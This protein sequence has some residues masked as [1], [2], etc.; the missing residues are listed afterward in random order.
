MEYKMQILADGAIV[1]V[2]VHD[3]GHKVPPF[4][5]DGIIGLFCPFLFVVNPDAAEEG[6]GFR[7]QVDGII[8][9]A[10]GVDALLHLRPEQIMTP[11]IL[12]FHTW[13]ELHFKTFVH[14]FFLLK[15]C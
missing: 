2:R 5:V 11:F 1:R 8:F 13:I 4:A 9:S 12:L 15:I 3:V 14:V 6:E 7:V 10:V